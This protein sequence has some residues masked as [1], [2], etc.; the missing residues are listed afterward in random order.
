[1]ANIGTRLKT[2]FSGKKIGADEFG[3]RYY[4]NAKKTRRWV[5]YNGI[6]EASKVPAEWHRWLHKT[7]DE[8]PASVSSHEWE[9]P[10]LPNLTG[11]RLAYVPKGHIKAGAKRDKTGGDYE[12]WQP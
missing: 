9:K 5:I 4:T 7:T 3:N 10:H 2:L 8:I 12:P 11:T 6:D 1:M